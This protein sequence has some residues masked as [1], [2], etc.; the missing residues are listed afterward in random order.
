MHGCRQGLFRQHC[1]AVFSRLDRQGVMHMVG[2]PN[3]DH[4]DFRVFQNR[5]KANGM[6]G[7]IIIGLKFCQSFGV[8]SGDS[9]DLRTIAV[10]DRLNNFVRNESS[11]KNSPTQHVYL[12]KSNAAISTVWRRGMQFKMPEVMGFHRGV[13]KEKNRIAGVFVAW[14]II[15]PPGYGP[16]FLV[17]RNIALP[18]LGCH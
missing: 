3:I 5:I 11:T 15:P 16:G 6:V 13:A 8:S 1:L 4:V 17:T 2:Q 12:S 9:F 10:H 14:K 7:N 18:L